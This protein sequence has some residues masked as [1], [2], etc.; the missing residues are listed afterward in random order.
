MSNYYSKLYVVTF[1]ACWTFN[2]VKVVAAADRPNVLIVL[3]DDAGYGDWGCHGHP[4][5]KTPNV[6]RLHSESI[7]FTDFHVAPMCSPTRG[8][9]LTGCHGLRTGVTSVTAGRTFLRPQFKT[10]PELFSDAGY[11]TGIFG[12]WHLGDSYPHRPMDK[13]F[14]SSYW[15]RGWGFT[16]TPE[17]S[18]TLIDG[19]I[20]RG[21]RSEKFAGYITDACFDEAMKWIKIQKN[22]NQQF[23]CYLPLHA[24]HSPHV[25][26][27]KYMTPYLDQKAPAFYGMIANI[28]ENMGRLDD[29]LNKVGLTDN[30]ITIFLTDNGGT[31][32]V[33]VYNAGLRA[34]KVTYYEGG[35]RV[36]CYIRWP[37]GRFTC[38]RDVADLT[39]VQDLL[40]T[41]LELCEIPTAANPRFDG[42]S[43]A[44]RLR[45]QSSRLPDRTLV[46]QF[47]PGFGQQDNSGPKKYECC[48]MQNQWRLV[49]GRELYNVALDREQV[50]NIASERPDIVTELKLEYETFWKSVSRDLEN[51]VPLIV[52]SDAEN[53]VSLTSADWQGAYCDNS[54]H[55]R[56]AEGGP[57]GGMWEIM[58]D[59]P[60]EYEIKLR[61][62][63]FDVDA[64]LDGY[65]DPPGKALPIALASVRIGSEL[66]ESEVAP[67]AA[68]AVFR[69]KL[70]AGQSKLQAWFS[71]SNRLPLCGAFYAKVERIEE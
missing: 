28:D 7:R 69:L 26:P 24:A 45:G 38:E 14:A 10:A 53:P 1:I 27:E 13:G 19:N 8:Q 16:S 44:S 65:I 71:D 62:W 56:D 25:V 39:E 35:H 43:L 6:D 17:F 36:P 66:R 37:N 22:N 49:N 41:L 21:T 52:G 31:A 63:P 60:G 68:E 20:L 4:F 47:G 58:V 32:G 33:K 9:L 67:K 34:G 54:R 64:T 59:K 46:V 2:F 61:R 40:P 50:K 57:M 51:F 55:I 70:A 29:F 11:Q 48:V 42:M 12:K 18:N 30:T 15:T 23:F 3:V 5:L